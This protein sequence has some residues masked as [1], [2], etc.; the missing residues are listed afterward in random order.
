MEE[1]ARLVTEYLSLAYLL[2]GNDTKWRRSRDEVVGEDGTLALVAGLLRREGE[3]E[4][5]CRRAL[6]VLKQA[7]YSLQEVEQVEQQEVEVQEARAMS[8]EQVLRVDQMLEQV[9]DSL[10]RQSVEGVLGEVATLA[11]SRRGQEAQEADCLKVALQGAEVQ[12]QGLNMALAQADRRK[13]E[14]ERH[15]SFLLLPPLLL[16]FLLL[17]LVT[18]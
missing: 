15:V 16:L 13:A 3:Q 5:R 8:P 9:T 4:A 18:P 12:V 11:L 1:Q 10:S 14:L 6:E 2:Q 17:L 7:D